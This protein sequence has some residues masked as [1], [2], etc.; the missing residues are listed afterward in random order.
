MAPYGRHHP[1]APANNW[2]SVEHTLEIKCLNF[3][4]VALDSAR[5]GSETQTHQNSS[6]SKI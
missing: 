3:S 5:S 4:F 2:I 6:L 1:T